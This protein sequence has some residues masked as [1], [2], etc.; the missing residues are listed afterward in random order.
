[1]KLTTNEYILT[2]IFFR[3]KNLLNLLIMEMVVYHYM[4]IMDCVILDNF[5][6]LFLFFIKL[7]IFY[8]YSLNLE[9]KKKIF[10]FF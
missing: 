7:L 3:L 4:D 8:L 10:C 5:Y 6:F 1:M 2:F 9:V